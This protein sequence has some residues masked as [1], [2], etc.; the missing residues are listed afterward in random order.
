MS[1][2]TLY[3]VALVLVR[4]WYYCFSGG[5]TAGTTILAQIANKY[6]DVSTHMRYCFDLIVVLI[7][8]TV[9]PLQM[10]LVTV[11]SLYI[12]TKVMEYVIEGLNTKKQ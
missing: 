1:S 8:L 6:L 7:S 9:L 10:A 12:G 11:I 3:L 2:L 4:H 5:T